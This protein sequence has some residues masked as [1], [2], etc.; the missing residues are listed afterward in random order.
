MASPRIDLKEVIDLRQRIATFDEDG[1]LVDNARELWSVD[2]PHAT[3]IAR[4][5]WNAPSNWLTH[6][7]AE[8]LGGPDALIASG[9]RYLENRIGAL[10][11][12]AWVE[13][14]E[15]IV[16]MGRSGERRSYE[17][18]ALVSSGA[19]ELLRV[20]A[21]EIEDHDARFTRLSDTISRRQSSP[22]MPISTPRRH[23]KPR[24]T[25]TARHSLAPSRRLPNPANRSG[26]WRNLLPTP[27]VA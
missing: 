1:R 6:D 22:P 26:H 10:G 21:M 15:Q 13:Q 8:V 4:N 18:L 14:L 7:R 5:F 2:E 25:N 24:L 16:L 11:E 20:V 23:A 17:L 27:R 12:F 3:T 19:R 9:K